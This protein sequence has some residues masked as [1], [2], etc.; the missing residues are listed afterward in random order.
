MALGADSDPN[1]KFS[2]KAFKEDA[3]KKDLPPPAEDRTKNS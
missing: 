1:R 2:E 3:I